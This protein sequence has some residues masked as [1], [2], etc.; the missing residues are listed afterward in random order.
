MAAAAVAAGREALAAKQVALE[1]GQADLAAKVAAVTAP[2]VQ[3]KQQLVQQQQA[4]Q[5][6]ARG[7]CNSSASGSDGGLQRD[8]MLRVECFLL[9]KGTR[10]LEHSSTAVFNG[11]HC[12]G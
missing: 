7:T 9:L 1:S 12:E 3:E 6:R 11:K 4:L 5:V 8:T 10:P 2:A